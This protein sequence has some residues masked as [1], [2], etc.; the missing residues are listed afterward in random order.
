MGGLFGNFE[1]DETPLHGF[2]RLFA[3]FNLQPHDAS[4]ILD[5]KQRSFSKGG[6]FAFPPPSPKENGQII[7][8]DTFETHD[9]LRGHALL[10]HSENASH[11]NL[12]AIDG[13]V[14]ENDEVEQRQMAE[15]QKRLEKEREVATHGEIE[16]VRSGGVL[17]DAQGR[18]DKVRTDHIRHEIRL[19]EREKILK[20]RWEMYERKWGILL[21]SEDCVSFKDMPWP[22]QRCPSSVEDLTFKAISDFLLEPLEIRTNTVTKRE[23]I[24]TSLLRWHPDKMS[25]VL[26]R[27]V[28]EDMD[29]VRGGVGAVF[30]CLKS[31]K[32]N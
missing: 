16:W 20:E 14:A 10:P 27:V 7:S 32:A 24:R 9:Q 17:R 11:Q 5:I 29:I 15:R 18:R 2:S 22:L 21:A 3:E 12:P 19:Q 31:M 23:R 1:R 4:S 28:E 6:Y 25:S 13:N 8:P 26:C 30:M